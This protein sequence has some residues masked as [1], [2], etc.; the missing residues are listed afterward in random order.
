MW[1]T[2]V[3]GYRTVLVEPATIGTLYVIFVRKSTLNKD[4]ST[5]HH[6]LYY[7]IHRFSN[8]WYLLCNILD[9]FCDFIWWLRD[10]CS[11][12]S[13]IDI[14]CNFLFIHCI[15]GP[16]VTRYSWIFD[17]RLCGY[18]Y[19]FMRAICPG[20]LNLWYFFC[21]Q[22]RQALLPAF[23][24]IWQCPVCPYLYLC[25]HNLFTS[26]DGLAHLYI[27]WCGRRLRCSSI[28]NFSNW[29]RGN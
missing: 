15:F 11:L 25:A 5:V 14:N 1:T 19:A 6:C 4:I 13:I 22:I 8:L 10:H 23:L 28:F 7:L 2:Y 20:I 3:V 26:D 24:G 17:D 16:R 12:A 27:G 29:L 9:A 18:W 21:A